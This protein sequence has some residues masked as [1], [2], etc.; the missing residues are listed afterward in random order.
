MEEVKQLL[1]LVSREL[2]SHSESLSRIPFK[3]AAD[4][5]YYCKAVP[6]NEKELSLLKH[7]LEVY[8]S[9]RGV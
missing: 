2:A 5:D 8:I 1:T 9:E 7:V 6:L 4:K 3:N